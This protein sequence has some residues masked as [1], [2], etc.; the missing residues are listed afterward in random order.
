MKDYIYLKLTKQDLFGIIYLSISPS[1]IYNLEDNSFII[2]PEISYKP[3]TNLELIT[4]MSSFF[5]DETSEYGSKQNK[6][7]YEIQLSTYF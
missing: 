4:K 5:G 3:Y 1:L 2:G 6:R 7:K